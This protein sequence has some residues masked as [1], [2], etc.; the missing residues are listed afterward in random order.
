MSLQYKTSPNSSI[1]R[2][3][4]LGQRAQSAV[5]LPLSL[6]G[7]RKYVKGAETCQESGV[8]AASLPVA[9]GA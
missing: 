2:C 5:P 3:G 4:S 1:L 7:E 8:L 6:P 9:K